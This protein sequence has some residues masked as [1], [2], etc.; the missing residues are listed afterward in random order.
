MRILFLNTD[1]PGFLIWLYRNQP[2]L[3]LR[4][5]GAQLRARNASL[6]GTADFMS[7]AMI[8]MGHAAIDV[9][10]NNRPLQEAWAAENRAGQSGWLVRGA[11]ALHPRLAHSLIPW[12]PHAERARDILAAQ[13][14]AFRPTVLYNHD[15]TGFS[16]AW[17]RSV[18]PR[19]CAMVAQI[20]SPRGDE[21]DWSAYD[22]VV[23]SLPN[24]VSWYNANGVAAEY[25]PLAFE[26]RVI[27]AVP[28]SQ[29]DIPLSFVG[30]VSPAHRERLSFLET[31]AAAD[32]LGLALWGEKSEAI[33]PESNL[34]RRHRG[35]A[36][37]PTMFSLLRRSQLTLNKHIDVSEGY[38]NNMRLFEATGMGT[39]LVTDWK[40]NLGTLFEPGKEA[41]AYHSTEECLDLLRYFRTHDAERAAIAAAGH[42]R[43]LAEH[44]YERRMIQLADM[45]QRRF[46]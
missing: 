37:G 41:V 16:A 28:E 20:A 19:D 18:L 35:D 30:S 8:R 42:A 21:T 43:C 27:A 23:S 36:W 13:I 34:H 38:A 11:S 12:S 24:F 9:H 14:A 17:L 25:L 31:I 7:E 4:T 6:F 44:R 29:S 10:A 45:L 1:Y 3:A 46:G 33:A 26:P 22:L 39:C 32:D 2:G 40:E 5:H 15:P